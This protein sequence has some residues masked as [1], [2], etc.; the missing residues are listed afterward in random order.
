MLPKP[1]NPDGTMSLVEHLDELR[2][3]LLRIVIGYVI[4]FA[5]CWPASKQIL[6]F[7]VRP[8]R[9]HLFEGGEIIFINPTEPF[10]IY[11]KATAI[12]ALFV[13]APYFLYQLW[14]FVV[15]GLYRRE[16]RLVVPFLVGGSL[17]FLAGGLFGYYV[18]TPV[19]AR[20]LLQLG[21]PFTAKIALRSAF[22]FESWLI[23]GMGAVFETP[24]LIYFL[25][26]LGLVTPRF[27]MRHFRVALLIIAVLSAVLTP[28][29][30]VV[31]MSVFAT[32]MIV[33]YLLGVFVAW[34]AGT[35]RSGR[36]ES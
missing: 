9:K 8:I 30:D 23:L 2:S 13:G 19:A 4:I 24:V 1:E 18:A 7:L 31:T 35:P 20:W 36:D 3:R 26:R 28:T 21:E 6:D 14:A 32:P 5:A 33:L 12:L 27:L 16:R 29:G 10:L 15:P 25:S 17:F 22:Q 34:V 11:M